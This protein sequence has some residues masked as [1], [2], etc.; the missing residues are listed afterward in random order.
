MKIV[1]K[2]NDFVRVRIN[3]DVLP[4][5]TA[6]LQPG[7]DATE[8]MEDPS[9]IIEEPEVDIEEPEEG[10]EEEESGETIENMLNE[11][12]SELGATKTGNVIEYDGQQIEYYSEPQCFAINK[13]IDFIIEGK[14]KK[15][16]TTQDVLDYLQGVNSTKTELEPAL[17]SRRFKRHK[18]IK[19]K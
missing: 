13:K 14:K 9:N 5:E 12:T 6:E 8:E 17:E 11:I 2:F 16:K 19:R 10:Y 7:L 15:L 3:E 18:S 4:Q 1:R